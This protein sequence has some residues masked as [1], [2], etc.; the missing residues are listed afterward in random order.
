MTFIFLFDVAGLAVYG[1]VFGAQQLLGGFCFLGL[2][3]VGLG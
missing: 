2:Y 3:F 1:L